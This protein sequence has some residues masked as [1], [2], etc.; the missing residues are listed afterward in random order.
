MPPLLR[1]DCD[2]CSCP[3]GVLPVAQPCWVKREAELGESCWFEQRFWL[4]NL[5]L[6]GKVERY[7]EAKRDV[8]RR[9]EH[10]NGLSEGAMTRPTDLDGVP[11]TVVLGTNALV[12][13][14]LYRREAYSHA[15]DRDKVMQMVALFRRAVNQAETA[16]TSLPGD[17][18][19]TVATAS[20]QLRALNI[21]HIHVA[22]LLHA[23]YPDIKRDWKQLRQHC[24]ELA[25][26][27]WCDAGV[28]LSDWP[29]F[30]DTRVRW[31]PD[32]RQGDF[33]WSMRNA[34]VT[35]VTFLMEF[36]IRHSM[37]ASEGNTRLQLPHVLIGGG[38]KRRQR[39]ATLSKLDLQRKIPSDG[40]SNCDANSLQLSRGMSSVIQQIA[41]DKY[42]ASARVLLARPP[43]IGL[44]WDQ[45][46]HG[47]HDM[48]V[49]ML[50]DC[51][52]DRGAYLSPAPTPSE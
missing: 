26:C 25:L 32:V 21:G 38:G 51:H 16:L 28:P 23:D 8:R 17:Q 18:L 31:S 24:P 49:G 50:L 35:L 39:F 7:R 5:R 52:S 36:Q 22:D 46:T 14:P 1:K 2:I 42:T 20:A 19:P 34:T 47:G 15:G 12:A 3:E 30:L 37:A 4:D 9:L 48:N 29:L 44:H 40:S 13:W 41:N 27:R 6:Y 33:L 10:Q 45:S 43:A 11:Q